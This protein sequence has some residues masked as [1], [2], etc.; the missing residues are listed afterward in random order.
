MQLSMTTLPQ[1]M[2][3]LILCALAAVASADSGQPTA[4]RGLHVKRVV[5]D[6]HIARTQ[7]MPIAEMR[8]GPGCEAATCCNK[9]H[10]PGHN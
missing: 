1:L 9:L 3:G 4:V 10:Q 7:G 5:H 8:L 2:L 6:L